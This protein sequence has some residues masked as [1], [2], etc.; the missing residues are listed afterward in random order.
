MTSLVSEVATIR[1]VLLLGDEALRQESDAALAAVDVL[2][3]RL[4]D[5]D[6]VAESAI[7]AHEEVCA[8][9][10]DL[11]ALLA[12]AEARLGEAAEVIQLFMDWSGASDALQGLTEEE[13]IALVLVR[14]T[15]RAFLAGGE[16]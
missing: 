5:A 4:A 1:R 7:D 13:V 3:A 16:S 2:T 11:E 10:D 12:A 8:R 6:Q 14:K 9:R 15:G